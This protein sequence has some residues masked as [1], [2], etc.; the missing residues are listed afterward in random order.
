MNPQQQ[1]NSHHLVGELQNDLSNFS[2]IF[3][4][5]D[6]PRVSLQDAVANC[7]VEHIEGLIFLSYEFADDYLEKHPDELLDRE[8]VASLNLYSKDSGFYRQLNRAL[9]TRDRKITKT[10]FPYMRLALGA[11][12]KCPLV[13]GTFTRGITNPNLSNYHNGRKPFVWWTFTSSTK[14]IS[15]TSDFLGDQNRMLFMIEGVG[16]DISRFADFP[17][18]EVLILPGSR[19]E[20]KGVLHDSGGLVITNLQQIAT[21]PIIDYVHP[22]LASALQGAPAP[23][24]APALIPAPAPAPVPATAPAPVPS[25]APAPVHIPALPPPPPKLTP[26]QQMQMKKD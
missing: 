12:F 18:A 19:F 20:V 10:F 6:T 9:A 3:G 15:I 4:L 2:P 26:Y 17:E 23:S 22:Q 16:V 25:P 8:E 11:M 5:K 1:A 24:P 14:E 7:G 21:P 13:K